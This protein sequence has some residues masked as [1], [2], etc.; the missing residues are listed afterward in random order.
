MEGG[1]PLG[2]GGD[3]EGGNFAVKGVTVFW[4]KTIFGIQKMVVK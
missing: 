2:E 3:D 1:V 4:F